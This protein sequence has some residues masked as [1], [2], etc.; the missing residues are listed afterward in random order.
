MEKMLWQKSLF[1]GGGGISMKLVVKDKRE[2]GSK[3]ILSWK[4]VTEQL[5]VRYVPD[6][7]KKCKS[8]Y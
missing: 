5:K 2:V 4:T 6:G 8:G 7:K 3:S 1:N